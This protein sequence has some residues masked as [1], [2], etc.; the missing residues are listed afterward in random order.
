VKVG[1][2]TDNVGSAGANQ[3][4]SRD[5]ADS[6]RSELISDGVATNCVTA[7]GYGQESPIADNATADGRAKNRRV[8]MIITER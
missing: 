7:E 8:A 2:Y 1:G 3:R 5:R 6:V 4:L